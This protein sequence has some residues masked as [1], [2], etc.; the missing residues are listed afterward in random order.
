MVD[1]YLH[2]HNTS[3]WCGA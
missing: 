2:S 1:L 3:S